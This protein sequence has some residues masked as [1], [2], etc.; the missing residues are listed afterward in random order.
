MTLQELWNDH[1]SLPEVKKFLISFLT[2]TG[3]QKIFNGEDT[4]YIGEAKYILEKAF[5]EI[6]N[7]F[8]PK[9]KKKTIKNESR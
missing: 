1:D 4:K 6:D 7:M 2:A 8:A 9:K 5:D 3:V